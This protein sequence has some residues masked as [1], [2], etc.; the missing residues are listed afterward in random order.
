MSD[1]SENVQGRACPTPVR[2]RQAVPLQ[3]LCEEVIQ[4]VIPIPRLR[5]R[6]LALSIF[7][8][9]AHARPLAGSRKGRK[10][11]Q[12]LGVRR[13]DAAFAPRERNTILSCAVAAPK[14][15]GGVKPPHSKV[16]SALG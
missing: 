6:N 4:T 12:R 16:P 11:A 15:H 10:C 1:C 7:K 9:V 13:L 14:F 8:A 5:D 3:S 2:G